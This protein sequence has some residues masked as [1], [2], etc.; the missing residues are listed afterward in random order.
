MKYLP[1]KDF[2]AVTDDLKRTYQSVIEEEALL[3]L[4]NFCSHRDDKYP[5]KIALGERIGRT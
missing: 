2:K 5:K 1:W 3:E 4:D